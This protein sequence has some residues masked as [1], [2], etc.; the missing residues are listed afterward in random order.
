MFLIWQKYVTDMIEAM[1]LDMGIVLEYPA[2]TNLITRIPKIGDVFPAVV[3][4]R[5]V[6]A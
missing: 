4:E 2:G 5:D 1:H 3:K 6:M